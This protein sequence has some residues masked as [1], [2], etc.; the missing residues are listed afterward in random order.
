M[1]A[2]PVHLWTLSSGWQVHGSFCKSSRTCSKAKVHSA[3]GKRNRPKAGCLT[4]PFC[5]GGYRMGEER[6]GKREEGKK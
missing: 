2:V 5:D 1:R 4:G 3:T 6:N